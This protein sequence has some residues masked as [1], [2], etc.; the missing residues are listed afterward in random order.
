[1]KLK[2]PVLATLTLAIGCAKPADLAEMTAPV[3]F[4]IATNAIKNGKSDGKLNVEVT[5]QSLKR[6]PDNWPEGTVSALV[7]SSDMDKRATVTYILNG[8]YTATAIVEIEGQARQQYPINLVESAVVFGQAQTVENHLQKL[9][10]ELAGGLG[11]GNKIAVF[12]A[13][14]TDGRRPV[15]GRS[16]SESLVTSLSRRGLTIVERKLLDGALREINFQHSGLSGDEV[17]KEMGRFLGADTV[18]VATVKGSKAEIVINARCV[19]VE[20]G[21]VVSSS[22]VIIPRYLIP[23]SD[24]QSID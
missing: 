14:S 21:T 9:A 15:F 11:P 6:G 20:R 2:Y 5:F 24:L 8:T 22:Q 3:A 17:R 1:M 10:N 23:A 18:L 12:D 16:V 19:S 7:S 4:A 13:E